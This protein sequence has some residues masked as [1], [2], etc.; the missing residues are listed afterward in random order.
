MLMSEK[1]IKRM[2]K[3]KNNRNTTSYDFLL[4]QFSVSIANRS[5][6]QMDD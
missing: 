3:V 2:L 4:R 6:I 5:N 1:T